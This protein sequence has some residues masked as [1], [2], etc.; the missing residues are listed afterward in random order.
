MPTRIEMLKQAGFSDAKIGDW[1]TAERQ[2][3]Q[4]DGF[5]D[6]EIDA[7][8][9]V[10]RPPK[11]VP[12]AFIARLKLGNAAGHI[13]G[14]AA[15]YARRYFG[16][17]PLGF[18]PQNEEFLRKLGMAGD[19]VIP[20]AK[21]VDAVLRAVPAGIAAVG[22]GVGQA[23]EEA[24]EAAFGPG[25]ESRGKAARDF[26][27]LAQ[28]AAILSGSGRAGAAPSPRGAPAIAL[29]RAEDFRNAA[30]AISG[31]P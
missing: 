3:M 19:I 8:F 10:T 26:A 28:I 5:T 13:A 16:D 24:G 22:A 21:P 27:S 6:D 1:A 7:D 31:T 4:H 23:V 17:A 2:R 12:D 15:D 30:A 14:A 20:A 18:S 29:P 11:E 9:G 25:P